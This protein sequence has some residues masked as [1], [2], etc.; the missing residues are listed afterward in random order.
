M[1]QVIKIFKLSSLALLFSIFSK[2]EVIAQSKRI[3][4]TLFDSISKQPIT[5]AKVS[6]AYLVNKQPMKLT[7]AYSD[8]TGHVSF[9]FLKEGTYKVSTQLAGYR[10]KNGLGTFG[11][12]QGD[13]Y[14]KL[15]LYLQPDK[16]VVK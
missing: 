10:P 16:Q 12:N 8:E 7:Q 11:P 13:F 2:Q 4:A 14:I 1:K 15:K 6:L 5:H 9:P 3:E